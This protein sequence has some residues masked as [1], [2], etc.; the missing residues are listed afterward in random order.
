MIN[1]EIY[2]FT[3]SYNQVYWQSSLFT[4]HIY[5][6]NLKHTTNRVCCA[7]SIYDSKVAI[8]IAS[9]VTRYSDHSVIKSDKL[10]DYLHAG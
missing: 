8:Y 6:A 5:S 7:I 3:S 10:I 9:Y 2:S 4:H 1:C